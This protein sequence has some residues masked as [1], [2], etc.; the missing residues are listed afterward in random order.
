MQTEKSQRDGKRIVPETRFIEF[1]VNFVS[2][3]IRLPQGWDFSVFIGDRC[4]IIFLAFA[5]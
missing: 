5:N 4:L 2:C 1:P 3:L